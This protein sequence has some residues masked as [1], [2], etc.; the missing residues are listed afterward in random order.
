M[1]LYMVEMW[2]KTNNFKDEYNILP[3]TVFKGMSHSNI[4][5]AVYYQ[6]TL[7]KQSL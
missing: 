1:K 4:L 3:I 5:G 7:E 2:V 6:R